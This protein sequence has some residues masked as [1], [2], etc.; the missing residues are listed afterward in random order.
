MIYT[1]LDGVEVRLLIQEHLYQIFVSLRNVCVDEQRPV[2][3]EG[4][5]RH[6]LH[7]ALEWIALDVGAQTDQVILR[8]VPLN[9]EYLRG[10]LSVERIQVVRVVLRNLGSND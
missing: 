1:H 2:E 4:A 5:M 3:K 6:Q 9:A 10:Q 8:M 7:F